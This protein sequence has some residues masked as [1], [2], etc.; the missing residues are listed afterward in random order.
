MQLLLHKPSQ[1]LKNSPEFIKFL[2]NNLIPNLIK[3]CGSSAEKI[4]KISLFIFYHI[5][6]HFK[7]HF[8]NEFMHFVQHIIFRNLE[9]VNNKFLVKYFNLQ[10]LHSIVQHQKNP[11]DFFLNFDCHPEAPDLMEDILQILSKKF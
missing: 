1:G 10:V 4:L 9:S 7:E 11:L 8:Y 3:N 2:R 6:Y 5:I